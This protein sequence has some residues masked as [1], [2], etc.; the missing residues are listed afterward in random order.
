MTL[1]TLQTLFVQRS[2]RARTGEKFVP[3]TLQASHGSADGA[4]SN[5]SEL[6]GFCRT[7]GFALGASLAGQHQQKQRRQNL[8]ETASLAVAG[9][10]GR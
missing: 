3:V 2:P 5:R 10:G 6:E 1:V 4:W 7:L 8:Y 9:E